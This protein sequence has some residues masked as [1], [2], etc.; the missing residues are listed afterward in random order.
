MG[1]NSFGTLFRMTSWGE[2]HGSSIGCVIDGCP[3]GVELSGE[4]IQRALNARLPGRNS[5]VS[6]RKEKDQVEILSGVFEGITTGCPIALL[7]NNEDQDSSKYE[8]IKELLRPGHANFTY[9]QK[10]GIFDF[11]GGGRASARETACRVAAGAVAEKLLDTVGV[12]VVS[13]LKAC[14]SYSSIEQ[15]QMG[16]AVVR[17]L[18]FCLTNSDEEEMQ[19]EIEKAKDAGDS[20]GGVV[21]CVAFNVPVGLGDPIFE[22]VEAKLASAMMSLPAAKAFEIGDGIVAAQLLG[23]QHNDLFC[24]QDGKISCSTNHAG[25]VLGGI[26]NGMPL[27]VRTHFKPASSIQK[28]Q[29]TVDMTGKTQKLVYPEG[30][31]HDPCVAIRAVPVCKAMSLLVLADCYLMN[32]H[33]SVKVKELFLK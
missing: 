10:Y 33:A 32:L 14:G 22:K 30:S 7:I 21:E 3:A 20:V 15:A 16:D 24:S 8:P 13:Y 2:S 27:I 23:S 9:L 12:K 18:L 4:D 11:R 5:L 28:E 26:T 31:R 25:G 6:A 29:A 19:A 1:S 17:P